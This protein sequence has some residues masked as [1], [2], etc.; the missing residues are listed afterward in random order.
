MDART[1]TRTRT[2]LSAGALLFAVA[3]CC[4]QSLTWLGTVAGDWEGVRSTAYGVTNEGIVVGETSDLFWS[5]AFRWEN[6]V[7]HNLGALSGVA[8][9]AYAV[10]ANGA[11]VV[12]Y[13]RNQ[14]MQVRAFRWTRTEGMWDI[15]PLST[16]WS[17]A[18]GVSADGSVVVGWA[19]TATSPARAFRWTPTGVAQDIGTLGGREAW[20]FGVS[21]DGQAI[22]G[23][24]QDTTGRY[25]AFRWTPT[26]RMQNLGVLPGY[27]RSSAF[28]VSADG[29]VVVGTVAR[30]NGGN[31]QHHAFRWTQAGGMQNLGTL[32]GVN[33]YATG[34]SG[35]GSIVVG[36]AEDANR[37]YRAFRWTQARGMEDLNRTY[38]YLI[39]A[40]SALTVAWAISPNGR[41]IVGSGFNASMQRWEAFL[42]DTAPSCTAHNGDVDNNRCIDDADL[43]AVLFAFG[44]AGSALGRRDVNCDGRVDDAD[45]LTVLFNFGSGC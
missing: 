41:Y 43:L 39:P 24:A 13:W 11:V 27:E 5:R 32:G 10:S 9:L 36:Y 15:A 20:A 16:Y 23:M 8:S 1:L 12:G 3:A 40:G 30:N 45:L 29:A 31:W 33:S 34:V 19:E 22:V 37:Q 6:G 21:A 35:D 7:M 44:E 26:G 4:S 42:L 14:S 2:L 18:R 17:E 25:R 28:A 38:A